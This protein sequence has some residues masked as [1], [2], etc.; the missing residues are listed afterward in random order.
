MERVNL[1]K[2][3]AKM[4]IMKEILNKDRDV[5]KVFTNSKT[6]TLMKANGVTISEMDKVNLHGAQE[7]LMMVNGRM[8][9]CMELVTLAR[10]KYS[11]SMVS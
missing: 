1:Q 11:W 6:E 8:T 3:L 4:N 5:V 9:L 10:K 2:A 7:K